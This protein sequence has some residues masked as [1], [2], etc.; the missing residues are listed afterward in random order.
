MQRITPEAFCLSLAHLQ[1]D[2]NG[3]GVRLTPA[4]CTQQ[5]DAERNP[6]ALE[7]EQADVV[8]RIDIEGDSDED[9]R[10]SDERSTHAR[11]RVSGSPGAIS[12]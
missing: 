2:K 5:H 11:P 12:R 7:D 6:R 4:L 1:S 10:R 3:H 8:D 9:A